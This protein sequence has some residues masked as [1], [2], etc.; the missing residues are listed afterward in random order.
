MVTVYISFAVGLVCLVAGFFLG[1]RNA[2]YILAKA[3]ALVDD[4]ERVIEELS[5]LV[6]EYEAEDEE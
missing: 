4:S 3:M 6:E 2:T 5:K 1:R